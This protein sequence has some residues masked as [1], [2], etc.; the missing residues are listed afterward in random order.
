MSTCI[1][2]DMVGGKLS[3][4]M[5][6]KDDDCIVILDKYPIDIGHSLIITKKQIDEGIEILEKT[7]KEYKS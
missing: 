2:C 1:F 4:H 3:C 6:Y 7:C 5:I